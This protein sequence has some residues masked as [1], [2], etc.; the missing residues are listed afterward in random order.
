MRSWAFDF[1][2]T[3][4]VQQES[5]GMDLGKEEVG[6]MASWERR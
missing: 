1:P 6:Q 5:G 3:V 4:G 2:R